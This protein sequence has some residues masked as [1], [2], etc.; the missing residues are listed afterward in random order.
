LKKQAW[1]LD[2]KIYN[3]TFQKK[4]STIVH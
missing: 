2:C 3:P 1:N 4:Q